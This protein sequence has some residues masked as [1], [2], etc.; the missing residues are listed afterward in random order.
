MVVGQPVN[1]IIYFKLLPNMLLL[2]SPAK[3]LDYD[4]PVRTTLSTQPMFIPQAQELIDIL[5]QKSTDEV[6]KLMKLSDALSQLNWQRFQDWV[7]EFNLDN[8]R[9][10]ILAF[11][12]DVYEGIEANSLSDEQ[13]QWAQKHLLILSGLYGVLRPLDL[14]QPYRLEM[15]TR[16]KNNIGKNLYEFWGTTI[17]DYINKNTDKSQPIINLASNEYFKSVDLKVLN[18]QVIDCV[19]QDYKNGEYK[20]ISFHAKRARGYMARYIIDNECTQP[21]QLQGFDIAGYKFDAQQSTDNS[22]VFR[23]KH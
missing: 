11:N 10:S 22:M 23:R 13:L 15:G 17:A 21:E 12:G 6:A 8:S 18:N 1:F 19:F 16:L 9:Q 3:K 14:M 4:S 7:S 2:I 5:K 20:I